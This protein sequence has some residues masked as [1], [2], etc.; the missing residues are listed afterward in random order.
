MGSNFGLELIDMLFAFLFFDL[1]KF[2]LLSLKGQVGLI[3]GEI[4]FDS[5]GIGD[6]AFEFLL[7]V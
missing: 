6:K 2:L 4:G 3:N 7:I 1:S 5:L